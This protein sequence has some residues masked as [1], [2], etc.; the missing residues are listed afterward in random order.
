MRDTRKTYGD[1]GIAIAAGAAVLAAGA[2]WPT[3]AR[4]TGPGVDLALYDGVEFL[5]MEEM[6]A[7]R[8]GFITAL[9]VPIEFGVEIF[10]SIDGMQVFQTSFIL[11]ESGFERSILFLPDPDVD[12][13][14]VTSIEIPSGTVVELVGGDTNVR[15]QDLM[16]DGIDLSGLDGTSG[17]VVLNDTGATAIVHDVSTGLLVNVIANTAS[18][19]DIQQHFEATI[20]LGDLTDFQGDVRFEQLRMALEQF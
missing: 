3:D 1:R 10:T 15:V 6:G 7:L 13:T 12:L 9:G 5:A 18:G 20:T 16:P 8:G 19:Q 4:A 14:G 17:F 2:L 11:T